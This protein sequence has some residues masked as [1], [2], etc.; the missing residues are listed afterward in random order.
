MDKHGPTTG[1]SRQTLTG[2]GQQRRRAAS[3]YQ[4]LEEQVVERGVSM[5]KA[6]PAHAH[7]PPLSQIKA[8]G[9]SALPLPT[10]G[11][12]AI[13]RPSSGVF[14]LLQAK[15]GFQDG[16]VR[17]QR[18]HFDCWL[19]NY[20]SRALDGVVTP[21]VTEDA[22]LQIHAKFFKNYA[23]WCQFLRTKPYL[24]DNQ[25]PGTAERQIALFLLV[26]G[27]SANM[28]FMPECICF[29]YHSLA[30][31]LE[32]AEK[33]PSVP[34]GSFLRQVVRPLYRVVAKMRDATTSGKN[35][36]DHKNIT[37]Y[38][39]VNEFFWTPRCLDFNEFNVADALNIKDFKTFK[40]RRSYFN[41]LLAFFRIYFFLLVML[42]LLIVIVYV[43]YRSD[44]GVTS[45][46]SFYSE[47]LSSDITDI[48]KHAFYSI[49]ITISGL[50][51]LKVVLDIWID[52]LRI[53]QRA[54]YAV[55]VFCRLVWHAVFFGIFAVV[56][57]SPYET[58]VGSS[59]MLSMGLIFIIVY[60]V[61][62][63]L[64][65][66][67]Q[68][69]FR[70][71]VWHSTFLSGLD[72]SR[73][74]FIGRHM[75]QKWGSFFAYGLF[76]MV[77]FVCKFLFNLQLMFKP[78]ITP[79]VEI[80]D[81]SVEDSDGIVQ[82][83]HNIAF[84]AAMWIPV[85]LVY[86][87]DTQIWLAILQAV[88]GAIIG[89]RRQIG[90]SSRIPEFMSR[91]KAA[92]KLFDEKVVS[93]AARGQLSIEQNPLAASFIAPNANSR[94]RF[95]VVW[96]E[97]VSSFR[98]SDLLDDRET[99]ILQYQISDTGAVEDP[100]FLIAGQAQT[101][102]DIASKAKSRRV[103]DSRL[104]KELEK[105]GVLGCSKNCLDIGFQIFRQLLGPQDAE[106]VNVFSE[107]L[108][109]GRISSVVNLVHV[110]LV[111]ENVV[112]LLASLLDL[113]EPA[114]VPVGGTFGFMHDQVLVIVQRVDA[115][116]KSIELMLEE[117]WMAEK[118]RQS[119]FAKVTPDLAYQKQQ[120]LTIFADR[121]SQR[122]SNSDPPASPS[123]N[124]SVISLSTRLFFLLTL[125]ATDAL[126]RCH[127]AQRRMSFFLNS[128]RMKMP[129]VAS[130]AAMRSFSVVT[131]YYNESVLYSI[132]E[133]N[134]RV[135][136]NP[137]FMK[138]EH[139]GRDLSILKYLIT[140]HED[141]WG[142]FLERAGVTSIEEAL[143][144]TPTQVRL[145]ASM[146]GQTL[147]RTVHGMMMYEDALKMLRWLEIGSD[148]NIS[149]L[150]K[151]KH[152]DRIAGLKFS[153]VTSC[154]IY[155]DQLAAGDS[156]AA[157]IDLLMRKYPN[158]R[159]S[160]VDTI[161]PPPGSDAETR[162]DCVLVKSDGDEIVE[163]YRYE[164]PGNP[165]VGEGK[166]ENQNIAI[167]FTRGEYLQT[168]DMNQEHYFE[169]ALKI[170]NFLATATE[171][172]ANVTII[173]MKEHIFTGRA[174]SLAHFMT[175]QELVFV[176]LTQR[177]MAT[178]LQSRMH[179]G[180]PD[181]FEKS[182]VMTNGSVSK[183]S[184][185]IN[186]SEDVFSGYNA[187]LRGEQ[188][189]H[190]EFMQCGKG[191]DVTLSQINAF[192]AK[193]SNGSAE[194]S[195]TRESH[196]LGAF[197]DFF[198]LNSVF[199]NH[200]GF[201]I[202]NAL[203]VFCV[204][205]YAYAKLY[206][207]LHL[208]V[209]MSAITTTG[210][211]DDLADVLNTQFIFQFG[212][213]MTIPL[214]AT[215]FVEYGWRQ[216]VLNFVELIVTLGP[217]FY[218]FETGTKAHFYD[219]AI[220]RGGSKY[221]GTGRGFAI[222]RETLVNFYKEY[223]A[224]HY[225]KAVELLGLM[226]LFGVYG[227]FSI[228][229]SAKEEYCAT[230][231]F[232]CD[233]NPDQ[234]PDNITLLASYGSKGQD[235][236]IASFA[237]WLLGACWL[238]APFFFNTDGLDFA[239]TR[240]DVGNYLTWMMS[241]P[242]AVDDEQ[243]PSNHLVPPPR[244]ETWSDFFNYEADLMMNV[245][246]TT[247]LAYIVRE[248]RHPLVMYYVFTYSF[249]LSDIWLLGVCVGGIAILLWVG[250]FALGLCLKNKAVELR[251]MLYMIFVVGLIGTGP[252]IAGSISDWGTEKAFSLSI[253]IF[254]GLYTI[255]QY[256]LILHGIMGIPV[257]RLGLAQAL[258]FL[259]D[260]V[261]GLFL[262]VPLLLFSALPFMTTIQTRMMYNGGFSRALSTGSEFAA[263]LSVVVGCL[264][265]WSY[266]WLSC[267]IF[268]LG[269]VN[270]KADYFLNESFRYFN[271]TVLD[272]S[273]DLETLKLFCA[274]AGAAGALLSTG[275]AHFVGRKAAIVA[276]CI[277][278][279]A[280]CGIVWVES[281]GMVVIGCCV[282][283]AGIAM[284]SVACPLYNFEICMRGWKGKGVLMFLTMAS[285]GYMVEAILLNNI[286][287]K[288]MQ[289]DWTNKP[290]HD[291]QLHFVFGAIPLVVLVVVMFFLPE[292]PSWQFRHRDHKLAETTLIRLRQKHDV[293]D[294]MA[295]I[296]DAFVD[297]S[298]RFNVP[299]RVVL[300]L[301]LQAA[302]ALLTSNALLLRVQVQPT[303]SE[304]GAQTSKWQIY[305]GIMTF[306]G[307]FL[308]LL[309]VDNMRRK[310]IFKDILP[311]VAGL[312]IACGVLGIAGYES[313][314]VTQIA[315]FVLFATA[316]LSLTCATWLTAVEVFPP[317]QRSR[318]VAMSF[319]FYY[320]VHAVLYVATPSFAI[321]HFVFAGLCL[322]L[323]IFMFTLCASAKHGAIIT[324]REKTLWKDDEA[325]H[326]EMT[327]FVARA[328]RSQSFLRSR[329]RRSSSHY[330][331]RTPHEGNYENFESPA[332][333]SSHRMS[334][335]A[336][337]SSHSSA[338]RRTLNGSANL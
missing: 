163:V 64:V 186:L 289:K 24:L 92:P 279:F 9:S 229:T 322:V 146:R 195:L 11:T 57:T 338:Y 67:V 142:N 263:S 178:P 313:S 18:E 198:R 78:L 124:E 284:L 59:D 132:D 25:P 118:M 120:L 23:R 177:V 325:S 172:G 143:A 281:A 42:H 218:I 258:G 20:E 103:D 267:L 309:T 331:T 321:S 151:I 286:N 189:T 187:T 48:R 312:A 204:F 310:T 230:A 16:N 114:V 81:V 176:S 308:S 337:A 285:L 190:V 98:L 128:L 10:A 302:F 305:Y 276:G 221:R 227:N 316:A 257:A 259:F 123:S 1:F 86:I 184:K 62:I 107:I 134:G 99:A 219:V 246:W 213:L 196:R 47:F 3:N 38:D 250:G 148:Q 253:A 256:L 7:H 27:E 307:T 29:L 135:N 194:S 291:W 139:K 243:L 200:M 136:S 244:K 162:Y 68:M 76:W 323:T 249:D 46:F 260:M 334:R 206:I 32:G 127:E 109:A 180:H 95:A 173:G 215:L 261:V 254:T 300:V 169:E 94:L 175:L 6:P 209:Q 203:V 50:L 318:F 294:E 167:P 5:S 53:F 283:A 208:E 282:A 231:S 52:G 75:N 49:F 28:R 2:Q 298:D 122:D 40:E 239:K 210:D 8:G 41:P 275:V 71:M 329:V 170:P 35:A 85:L 317:Y 105:A 245:V 154:Q 152:M 34:E 212:M 158:W 80:Y 179:Y 266:G 299:F 223:A 150:D 319:V 26:W 235:Y 55:A 14:E 93:A 112:D 137:L 188:V 56:N 88:I 58:L 130:I 160:Y 131:P 153:Y 271:N 335:S 33:M 327:S 84:L 182:F 288:A 265:G 74:Q 270:D 328:S 181:V 214:I 268:S 292:S 185:G 72:G 61:P 324:K 97:I 19:L 106:V 262:L 140:F 290:T 141:E 69:F 287:A 157:D 264:G 165:M 104:L 159:V 183:A 115:L 13:Q 166:P 192:E 79:T 77:I 37:N 247:R 278:T 144:E 116:L 70:G 145:W 274:A 12:V 311:L 306:V 101:A 102:T 332:A 222:V 82:S 232:D 111:R 301:A 149:H 15:F 66:I 207:A 236:G 110:P 73:E 164:L 303:P 113:P 216:A 65:S 240:A 225:R 193:L 31:K 155:S 89:V 252:F 242:D 201:Y 273:V 21:Q 315:L 121:M 63:V 205:A 168:I 22:V 217:L 241:S 296:K 330:S 174:S 336:G 197:L 248:A 54:L 44:P 255:L 237:V 171:N 233:E 226:I 333:L 117:E 36:L 133:L 39:D 138:V 202:C 96:N 126:P 211:L 43:A 83:K 156:R 220:M 147:A 17:N 293:I 238:L 228:G 100:V 60:M 326:K 87:Y 51:A 4:T 91:L 224:S 269:F 295:D 161:R 108:R 90:H 30:S 277:V 191:R 234:I 280:G 199:Y 314:V 304:N 45:G 125:D 297:K 272:D 251:G 119:V 320:V 129:S